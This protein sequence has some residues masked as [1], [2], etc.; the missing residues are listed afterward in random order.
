[1]SAPSTKGKEGRRSGYTSASSPI[2]VNTQS[3]IVV[4]TTTVITPSC[5]CRRC[6]LPTCLI[7]STLVILFTNVEV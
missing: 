1:M 3:A 4:Y 7:F 2:R 5:R 6:H